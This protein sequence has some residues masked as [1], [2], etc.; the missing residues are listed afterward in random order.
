MHM[1]YSSNM[2]TQYMSTK[3]LAEDVGHP[4]NTIVA[5]ARHQDSFPAPSVLVGR[6]MGWSKSD[7]KK[8]RRWFEQRI[9]PL[10]HLLDLTRTHM[11]IRQWA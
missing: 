1:R 9:T 6:A 2:P 10:V 7:A 8:V 3:E 11:R 4:K 5:Y